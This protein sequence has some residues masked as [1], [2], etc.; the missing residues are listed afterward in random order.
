MRLLNR[1]SF[2]DWERQWGRRADQVAGPLTQLGRALNWLNIEW[3]GSTNLTCGTKTFA[4]NLPQTLLNRVGFDKIRTLCSHRDVNTLLHDARAFLRRAVMVAEVARRPKDFAGLENSW[5]ESRRCRELMY[6][7]QLH[8]GGPS[9]S[10]GGLWTQ[11]AITRI[12]FHQ[13][14]DICP[15]CGVEVA[16]AMHRLWYCVANI[17]FRRILDEV[18]PGNNFPNDLPACL[19][20][21]GLIPAIFEANLGPSFEGVSALLDYLAAADVVKPLIS[22]PGLPRS[23]RKRKY[24]MLRSLHLNGGKLGLI[25]RPTMPAKRCRRQSSHHS[26][27]GTNG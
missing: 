3:I 22:F 10:A 2:A 9:L 24:T 7:L 20:R 4:F 13:H 8:Y 14:T 18:C 5:D 12:P 26:L 15:R 1:L 6:A 23:L 16:N 25:G 17:Q 19:C 27:P 21:C 11:L